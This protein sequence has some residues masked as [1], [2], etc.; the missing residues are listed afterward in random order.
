VTGNQSARR[1]DDGRF[2]NPPGSPA[3]N[4]STKTRWAF[5]WERLTD[6]E[7]PSPPPGLLHPRERVLAEAAK[8]ANPSL[9]WLGHAAFLIRLGGKTILTDPFLGQRAGPAGFGPRRFLPPAMTVADLPPID[10]LLVSHNH[11]DHLD[12]DTVAALPGKERM[13]VVV[14]LGL[15]EFFHRRGYAKVHELDWHQGI[16]DGAAE[17]TVLPAVH[18]SRRG[19]RDLNRTL[20]ASFAIR[21]PE[22]HIWFSGDTAAGAVFRELGRDYGPFDLAIVGIGA[23][24][25]RAI[26]RASHATPEEAITIARDLR[27]AQALGMH[28]GSIKLTPEDPFEAPDRFKAAAVA[29]GYGAERAWI[30]AV[31]ETRELPRPA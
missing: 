29:Q 15:A 13:T 18:F 4:S 16:S 30:M 7:R 10:L 31:G 8:A 20:W 21:A 17:V 3:R 2:R 11:Y 12:A 27:A 23:Y 24:E 1:R 19:L 5:Y 28:W 6:R 22:A 26:M 25:P 14:P 9:T